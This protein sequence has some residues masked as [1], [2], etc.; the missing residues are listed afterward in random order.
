MKAYPQ[1]QVWVRITLYSRHLAGHACLFY[2]F[3]QGG[4]LLYTAD[5]LDKV[6]AATVKFSHNVTDPK[7]QIITAYSFTSGQ[8]CFVFYCVIRILAD[9]RAI[10]AV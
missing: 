7:A 3:S 6:N 10:F 4:F 9:M 5:Q 2:S 8:V 1:G